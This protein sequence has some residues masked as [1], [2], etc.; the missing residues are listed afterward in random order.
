[1]NCRCG[2]RVDSLY[3]EYSDSN[4]RLTRCSCCGQVAD[5]YIEFEL[6]L[7]I[8]DVLLHRKPAYRHLMYNRYDQLVTKVGK[9]R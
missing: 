1:M 2:N 7:V 6:V 8:I 3:I 4:F 5:K 9:L